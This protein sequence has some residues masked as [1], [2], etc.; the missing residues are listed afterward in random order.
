M[1]FNYKIVMVGASGVGKS[2]IA[3]RYILNTFYNTL[4]SSIGSSFYS[5]KITFTSKEQQ[6]MNN[7]NP[8]N[9]IYNDVFIDLQL[10]DTAGQERYRSLVPFYTRNTDI[11]L[12]VYDLNN[13][14]YEDIE[15][16][17][18]Y[19]NTIHNGLEKPDI[20][21]IGNKLDLLPS[22]NPN[23]IIL[24]SNINSN[25]HYIVSAKNNSGIDNLFNDVIIKAKQK[26]LKIIN[27]NLNK[28]NTNFNIIPNNTISNSITI[29]DNINLNSFSF[30]NHITSNSYKNYC[31]YQ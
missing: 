31:C 23:D 26:I 5:N 21:I 16:W 3:D 29:D 20:F 2:S 11:I 28:N 22:K 7:N 17:L 24:S 8:D 30:I 19:S 14:N 4:K 6:I 10:W 12:L 27:S 9:I 18:K 13:I 25:N 15:Y 1:I